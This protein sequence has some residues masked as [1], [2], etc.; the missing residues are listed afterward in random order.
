MFPFINKGRIAVLKKMAN[1]IFR[2]L[3][4]DSFVIV[5]YLSNL[6]NFRITITKIKLT[7]T[8]VNDPKILKTF[9]IINVLYASAQI[10]LI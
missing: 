5:V 8:V 4:I 3:D 6:A 2:E 1:V 7:I 9:L 10:E